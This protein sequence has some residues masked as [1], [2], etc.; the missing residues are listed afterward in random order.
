MRTKHADR[1]PAIRAASRLRATTLLIAGMLILASSDTSLADVPNWGPPDDMTVWRAQLQLYVCPAEGKLEYLRDGEWIESAWSGYTGLEEDRGGNHLRVRLNS[2]GETVLN[3][4]IRDLEPGRSYVYDLLLPDVDG[5]GSPQVSD[6]HFLEIYNPSGDAVQLCSIALKLNE[7]LVFAHAA[8]FRAWFQRY[9]VT[10][11]SNPLYIPG[12][13]CD[14]PGLYGEWHCIQPNP[15]FTVPGVEATHFNHYLYW[16]DAYGTGW[17]APDLPDEISTEMIKSYAAAFT[18]TFI[19]DESASWRGGDDA[20]WHVVQV[21]RIDDA[22]MRIGV[23]LEG[24]VPFLPDVDIDIDIDLR[25]SCSCGTVRATPEAVDVRADAA[26]LTT[27]F[28]GIGSVL[29]GR[30]ADVEEL[31]E[32]R[33][34]S[35]LGLEPLEIPL[36]FYCP[37][38]IQVDSDGSISFSTKPDLALRFLESVYGLCE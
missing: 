11:Y 38:W 27:A 35:Q 13:D 16:I 19:E 30:H 32:R 24:P 31:I 5:N 6:I 36:G 34:Q 21:S 37:S 4:P 14:P 22:A 7:S 1:N 10:L 2:A 26:V 18:G 33:I 29:S 8:Y 28:A 3:Q 23:D 20:G 15:Y 25:L 9:P 17:V 12:D